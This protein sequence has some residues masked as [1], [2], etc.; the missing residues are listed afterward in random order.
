MKPVFYD[1]H[2]HSCLSPCGDND[3][4]V[5]NLL[6]MALLKELD[7]VALTDHN[8]CKNCPALMA[9]AKDAPITVLPGMELTTAE[10]IHMVCLFSSLDGAMGF[11]AYAWERLP[12]IQNDTRIFGDQLI[13]NNEDKVIGQ[14]GKLLVNATSIEIGEVSGLMQRF[15][16]L[17]YPA[18]IDRSSYSILSNLGFIPP[19]Y[20]FH[21]VE[22]ANPSGFFADRH[23]LSIKECYTVITSSD[24]HYLEQISEREHCIH[25][26]TADFS[27]LAARLL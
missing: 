5:N 19:E 20:G 8:S 25:L 13:L 4:T 26:D 12:D 16:G 21:T 23:N 2:L 10:E 18:H 1:L 9:A 3:M 24:A 15:G 11:D 6:N 7:M 22:V 14:E 27:G 17:C